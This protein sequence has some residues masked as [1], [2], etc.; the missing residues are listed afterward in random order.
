MLDNQMIRQVLKEALTESVYEIIVEIESGGFDLFACGCECGRS[1]HKAT[2]AY[3]TACGKKLIKQKEAAPTTS[4]MRG[5]LVCGSAFGAKVFVERFSIFFAL[6][7]SACHFGTALA[8][9][10]FHW[11]IF[12]NELEKKPAK[13]WEK[14][15]GA[16]IT[17]IVALL[18][19]WFAG[20]FL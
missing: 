19:G 16:V 18:L 8:A 3:C 9:K 5:L 10:F 14:M 1:I 15:M 2:A 4:F 12:V 20:H 6:R 17:G 13:K 7:A 11:P